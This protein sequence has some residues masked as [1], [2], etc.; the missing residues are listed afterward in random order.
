M[1]KNQL[2]TVEILIVIIVVFSF[3]SK[4]KSYSNDHSCN[5]EDFSKDNSNRNEN[6]S[7][8]MH[9]I[10]DY[11][12]N[13]VFQE[14]NFGEKSNI[15]NE[16]NSSLLNELDTSEIR[17]W[18]ISQEY[19]LFDS[20][21]NSKISENV[22]LISFGKITLKGHIYWIPFKIISTGNSIQKKIKFDVEP[23]LNI[24]FQK[25]GFLD[26]ICNLNTTILG[27]NGVLIKEYGGPAIYSLKYKG[28]HTSESIDLFWT[29]E[30]GFLELDSIDKN[31]GE[32]LDYEF[33]DRIIAMKNKNLASIFSVKKKI[34][35]R[36]GVYEEY[37]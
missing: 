22:S 5:I 26:I 23:T 12:T 1:K 25:N 29:S 3:F 14:Q 33:R 28:L 36:F 17:N 24:I 19:F 9:D 21:F 35:N 2:K 18:R 11:K 6:Y 16:K 8:N 34:K 32:F 10:Y 20:L 7:I 4:E 13:V 31:K 37:K 30:N 15:L 27:E